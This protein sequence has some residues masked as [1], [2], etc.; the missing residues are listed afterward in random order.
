MLRKTGLEG[1]PEDAFREVRLVVLNHPS[2]LS[3]AGRQ[4][5]MKKRGLP[6]GGLL[7]GPR[8]AT[9]NDRAPEAGEEAQKTSQP[10]GVS[11]VVYSIRR[12]LDGGDYSLPDSVG[13][14]TF[15]DE[16]V[17]AGT[18]SVAYT[19]KAKRGTQESDWSEALTLRF[20]RGGGGL[21]ITSSETTPAGGAGES[22]GMKMAA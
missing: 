12:S 8:G 20:G 15:T 4:E 9:G 11:G 6:T 10:A 13:G 16:T 7:A 1:D 2:A 5:Q 17:P 21:T 19:I 3:R 22:D 14:K 18:Q